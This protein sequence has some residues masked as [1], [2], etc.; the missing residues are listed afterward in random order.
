[1][2]RP[3]TG[4]DYRISGPTQDMTAVY[5]TNTE[6]RCRI[7]SRTQDMTAGY[8]AEYDDMTAGY[9]AQQAL[10]KKGGHKSPTQKYLYGVGNYNGSQLGIIVHKKIITEF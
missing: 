2:V 5:P 10:E 6:Y 9:P 4:Y 1:M 7:S 3:N 8:P